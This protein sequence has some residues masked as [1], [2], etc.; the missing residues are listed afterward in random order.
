MQDERTQTA[1]LL[2]QWHRGDRDALDQL[3]QENADWIENRVRHRLGGLLRARGETVDYV[4]E[5]MVEVLR[6]APRFVVSDR[7]RFRAMLARMVENVLRDEVD[8]HKALRRDPRR[9][10]PI[11]TDSVLRLDSGRHRVAPPSE[12]AMRA[13]GEAWI[14][15][16][17]ELIEPEDRK[18]ILL[19][20]HEGLSFAEVGEALGIQENTARMRFQRAL[21]RLM[22]K[23][24][25]L[26]RAGDEAFL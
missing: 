1:R 21:P 15:L 23:V 26:R 4:Q 22:K 16:A 8:R 5:V 24:E 14:R 10:Q 3:V 13:E 25:S 12:H 2:N 18:V 9:E 11:P 7:Q 17:L 20:E 6:Y 19:R